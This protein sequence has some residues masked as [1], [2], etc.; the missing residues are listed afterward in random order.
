MVYFCFSF[1]LESCR[2]HVLIF[3]CLHKALKD[4]NNRFTALELHTI[5]YFREEEKKIIDTVMGPRV[6]DARIR[7]SGVNATGLHK[8]VPR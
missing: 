6:Y 7:P 4:Y 2:L 5:C 1:L 8:Q 3:L